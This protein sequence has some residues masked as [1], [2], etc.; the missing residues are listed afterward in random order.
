[1]C[2]YIYIERERERKRC[3]LS[4]NLARHASQPPKLRPWWRGARP[5]PQRIFYVRQRRALN[6]QTS[7]RYNHRVDLHSMT[8]KCEITTQG[9]C[10]IRRQRGHPGVPQ[11]RLDGHNHNNNDNNNSS[12]INDSIVRILNGGVG[13][14]EAPCTAFIGVMFKDICLI[15]YC[16]LFVSQPS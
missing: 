4:S 11:A 14:R 9:S 16:Y 10:L 2:I 12:I 8:S 3:G 15:V 1:M 13:A 6:A 5:E 7:A